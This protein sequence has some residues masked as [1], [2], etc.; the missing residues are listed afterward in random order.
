MSPLTCHE[1]EERIDLCAVGECDAA[2]QAAVQAHLAHCPACALAYR[3]ALQLAGA[4]DLHFQ[5]PERLQ[6]LEDKLE[7]ERRPRRR[8]LILPYPR[9]VA[10]LAALVLLTFGLQFLAWPPRE[11]SGPGMALDIPRAG[12]EGPD[13]KVVA[14]FPGRENAPEKSTAPRPSGAILLWASRD[15]RWRPVTERRIE[16]TSGEMWWEVASPMVVAGHPLPP[17]EVSTPAGT[18]TAR[19]ARFAVAVQAPATVETGWPPQQVVQVN[20]FKG[21]VQLTNAP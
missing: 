12:R 5:G 18:V 10:A 14:A 19:E 16:L 15:A 21:T 11:S 8:P 1:V 2:E 20:V 6:R 17:F 3:E 9:R 13:N 7:A 4:L